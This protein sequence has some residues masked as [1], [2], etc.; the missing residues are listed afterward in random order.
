[1]R[2]SQPDAFRDSVRDLLKEFKDVLIDLDRKVKGEEVIARMA[3]KSNQEHNNFGLF[4]KHT[5][6]GNKAFNQRIKRRYIA[7]TQRIRN[8]EDS[9][10]EGLQRLIPK[11]VSILNTCPMTPPEIKDVLPCA[12]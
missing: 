1:M 12:P 4:E 2:P 5:D 6:E 9:T 10:V 11:V 3:E 7:R 8:L